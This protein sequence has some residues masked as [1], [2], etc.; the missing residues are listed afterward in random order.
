MADRVPVGGGTLG[1]VS[2]VPGSTGTAPIPLPGGGSMGA[3]TGGKTPASITVR[4]RQ[5]SLATPSTPEEVEAK[6]IL[7]Q[8]LGEMGL[9]SLVD[10]AYEQVIVND[11]SYDYVMKVLAPQQDLWKQRFRGNEERKKKNLPVLSTEEYLAMERGYWAELR[12]AGVASGLGFDTFEQ[13]I[14]SDLAAGFFGNDESVG[15]VNHRIVNNYLAL[16]AEDPATRNEFRTLYGVSEGDLVAYMLD[17]NLAL[18]VLERRVAAARIS[19]TA[20]TAGF[21]QLSAAEAER[22]A[23]F[24]LS[25]AEIEGGFGTLVGSAQLFGAFDAGEDAIGR[26]T[27][28][29]AL[30]GDV[31]AQEMIQRRRRKRLAEF[32]GGGAYAKNREGLG[33]LGSA[34]G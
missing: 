5:P 33:G 12:T 16:A 31:R 32:S 1:D 10:W 20:V 15:E 29:A 14:K 6:G 18:P 34:A 27:Q 26:G 4:P 8:I 19:G 3:Y 24:G 17:A 11:L 30:E 21:G 23:S 28:L 13:F 2:R 22:L 25:D 7:G 9:E